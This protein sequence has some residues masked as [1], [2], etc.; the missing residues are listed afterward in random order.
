M[1]SDPGAMDVLD[2]ASAGV[3]EL[4]DAATSVLGEAGAVGELVQPVVDALRN[5]WEGYFGS[6]IPRAGR[7]G[8]PTATKSCTGCSGR[9]PT[10]GT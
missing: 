6:P 8:T 10:S 7:T 3:Q 4:A 9:T 2:I 5:V 1:T